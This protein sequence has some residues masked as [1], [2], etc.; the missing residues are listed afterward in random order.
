MPIY[1]NM[2]FGYDPYHGFIEQGELRMPN[3]INPDRSPDWDPDRLLD[4]DL[5]V[6]GEWDG[7]YPGDDIEDGND[8]ETIESTEVD[9]DL[10]EEFDEAS[11]FIRWAQGRLR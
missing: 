8:H 2:G 3:N 1:T 5:D 6:P 9:T 7:N 10:H 11:D 4:E